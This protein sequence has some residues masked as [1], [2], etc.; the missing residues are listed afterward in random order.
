M[1]LKKVLEKTKKARGERYYKMPGATQR[2]KQKVSVKKPS[3]RV[4][5][6]GKTSPLK[7][8]KAEKI[9]STKPVYAESRT[10]SLDACQLSDNRC[11]ALEADSPDI[12]NYKVIR[13]KIQ[14]QAR[15]KG[16][17]TFMI[18]SALPGEGKTHTAANLAMVFARA[19][20]QTVLLVD[21]DLKRQC[22]HERLGFESKTNLVDHLL[23]DVPMSDIIIWPGIEKLTII[24]GQ[25]TVEDSSELIGSDKMKALFAE[26]KNR[27]ADRYILFDVPPILTGADAMS[28]AALVDGIIVVVEA[29]RT[30]M[31]DLEAAVRMIPENKFIGF[32]L[33]RERMSNK[34]KYRYYANYNR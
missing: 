15:L 34:E 9:D 5:M 31:R 16:W 11:L 18:T 17:N 23:D 19:Y 28:F 21:C 20:N 1:K 27:Y 26:M 8:K 22:I 30:S 29:R 10:V 3:A 33:N 32:V 13:T 7:L 2:P 4:K 25:R 12:E 24:S 6:L 14:H